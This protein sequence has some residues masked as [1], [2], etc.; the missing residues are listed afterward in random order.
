MWAGCRPATRIAESPRPMPQTVR[1]PYMSLRVAK[2][3]AV[4]SQVRVAGLVTI[5]PTRSRSVAARIRL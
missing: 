3:E 2:S 5:G 1:L 4:T